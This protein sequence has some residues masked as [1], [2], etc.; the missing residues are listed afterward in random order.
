MQRHSFVCSS[1]P[2][3]GKKGC[4]I[5][6]TA[7]TKAPKKSRINSGSK[8]SPL[9]VETTTTLSLNDKSVE[10]TSGSASNNS[11]NRLATIALVVVVV[12]ASALVLA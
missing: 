9:L 5:D 4:A 10:F 7:G 6:N 12:S 8:G 11:G 3:C 2:A 1:E